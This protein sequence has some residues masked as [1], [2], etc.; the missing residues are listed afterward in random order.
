MQWTFK[1]RH[2]KKW[3][4]I[5]NASIE[6]EIQESHK[7]AEHIILDFIINKVIIEQQIKKKMTEVEVHQKVK[8]PPLTN[9]KNSIEVTT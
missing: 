4:L 2:S 1:L 7:E 9:F 6:D 8:S 3:K 5:L